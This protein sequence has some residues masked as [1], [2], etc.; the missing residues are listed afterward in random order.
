MKGQIGFGKGVFDDIPA[1]Q[2]RVMYRDMYLAVLVNKH[3]HQ[4]DDEHAGFLERALA[5]LKRQL[6]ALSPAD[7][8]AAELE[9]A[10]MLQA[11]VSELDGM[12]TLH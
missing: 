9:A 2:Q 8:A 7:R 3:Q 6:P 4:E 1:E 5:T 12:L 11:N 10:R